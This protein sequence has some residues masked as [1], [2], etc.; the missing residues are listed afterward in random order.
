[1]A[2]RRGGAP[3]LHGALGARSGA[4]LRSLREDH[5]LFLTDASERSG[6][7]YSYLSEVE[8]GLKMPTLPT[9]VALCDAYGMLVTEFLSG[10]YPF[11]TLE[12]PPDPQTAS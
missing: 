11:G 7:S 4:R 3:D 2:P 1:M 10:M 5:Q 12:A 9:L 8:R 6:V